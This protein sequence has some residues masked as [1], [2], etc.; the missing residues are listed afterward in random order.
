MLFHSYTMSRQDNLWLGYTN[1]S[2]KHDTFVGDFDSPSFDKYDLISQ[3]PSTAT[4]QLSEEVERIMDDI[5]SGRVEMVNQT[6]AEFIADMRKDLAM[7][8]KDD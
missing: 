2:G 3:E 4:E 8:D 7:T 6:A 5:D 1:S